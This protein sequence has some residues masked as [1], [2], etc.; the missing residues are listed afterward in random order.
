MQISNI[1]KMQYQLLGVYRFF[2]WVHRGVAQNFRY[3][4]VLKL[5][6]GHIQFGVVWSNL[7]QYGQV[8][9]A[10]G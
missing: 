6:S 10:L 5:W 2:V 9:F 4:F 3:P 1:N 8:W 7:A